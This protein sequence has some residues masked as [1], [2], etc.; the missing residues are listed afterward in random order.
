M[1]NCYLSEFDAGWIAVSNTRRR[2]GFGLAWNAEVFRYI[3]L[4]QAFGG[5]LGYPWYGRTYN[6]GIE[7]WNSFP[8]GGLNEALARGTAMHLDPGKSLDTWLTA[9]AYTDQDVV[10]HIQRDGTVTGEE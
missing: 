7:P 2:V 9:V 6:M 4:W 8:C 1:D 3:W 5:G 10:T